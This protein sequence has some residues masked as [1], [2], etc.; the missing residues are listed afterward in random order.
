MT[1]EYLTDTNLKEEDKRHWTRAKCDNI[2]MGKKGGNAP[3][4]KET[5][6]VIRKI[7]NLTD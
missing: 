6:K 1:E 7:E 4:G 3:I 2:W 5:L